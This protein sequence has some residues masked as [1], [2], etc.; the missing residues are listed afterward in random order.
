M[1]RNVIVGLT[2]F[3]LVG[4]AFIPDDALALRYSGPG[5]YRVGGGGV[6]G[7]AVAARGYAGRGYRGGAV[8]GRGVAYRGVGAYG[9]RYAGGY[10][11]RGYLGH[12][13]ARGAAVAAGTAAV[14]ATG[15]GGGWG[16]PYYGGG[17]G[18]AYP[19]Y[20]G[21][22][23]RSYVTGRPTLFPRYYGGGYGWGTGYG[24][25]AASQPWDYDVYGPGG[26]YGAS[27][28]PGY[29]GYANRSYVTG[30]PTLFPR[31]YGW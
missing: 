28:Y 15:W 30:R 4:M 29:G 20:G 26:N 5:G 16:Q 18:T 14:A 3:L 11:G 27:A 21:Y 2:A 24:A 13:V 1:L 19:G 6:R 8:A 23:N 9:G 10:Y 22:A 31:Y 7:G 17:W 12:P 25:Y